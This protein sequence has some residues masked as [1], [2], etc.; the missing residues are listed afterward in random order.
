M[1]SQSTKVS[2][3]SD[4]MICAT[5]Q[6]VEL[7]NAYLKGIGDSVVVYEF[8]IGSLDGRQ[9]ELPSCIVGSATESDECTN[10]PGSASDNNRRLDTLDSPVC[11]RRHPH[12]T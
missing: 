5:G 3:E 8:R 6:I 4:L 9:F 10:L 7:G 11:I 12:L 2:L 1:L